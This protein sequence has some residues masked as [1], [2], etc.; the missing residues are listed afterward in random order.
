MARKY[1]YDHGR[2]D[3]LNLSYVSQM[4]WGLVLTAGLNIAVLLKWLFT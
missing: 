3:K 1:S 4:H 2:K